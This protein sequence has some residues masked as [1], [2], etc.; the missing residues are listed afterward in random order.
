MPTGFAP[1]SVL[2][3]A[4]QHILLGRKEPMSLARLAVVSSKAAGM[5]RIRLRTCGGNRC[6]FRASETSRVQGCC[7][8]TVKL[9]EVFD[10]GRNEDR[11]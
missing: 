4:G 1:A 8:P 2:I 7:S 10:V 6:F 5:T 9:P 3:K 11:R